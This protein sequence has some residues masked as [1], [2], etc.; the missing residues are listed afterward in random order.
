VYLYL[1]PCFVCCVEDKEQ[2]HS[3]W[4]GSNDTSLPLPSTCWHAAK[5]TT[6]SN[7]THH[8][9][10][11]HPFLL[12]LDLLNFKGREE[13]N[14]PSWYL[15]SCGTSF[16][17]CPQNGCSLAIDKHT[18]E[19][20]WFTKGYLNIPYFFCMRFNSVSTWNKKVG[21]LCRGVQ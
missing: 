17:I 9:P 3:W 2:T 4:W 11:V 5:K 7:H 19:H 6:P 16:V 13:T 14:A 8:P 1:V 18:S 21:R 10:F 15:Y 20:L 12:K